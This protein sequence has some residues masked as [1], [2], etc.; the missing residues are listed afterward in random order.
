MESLRIYKLELTREP[1]IIVM[2]NT[3]K[4]INYIYNPKDKY[5]LH[6]TLEKIKSQILF[7]LSY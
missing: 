7:E 2:K 5:S 6:V 4:G 3:P 1:M